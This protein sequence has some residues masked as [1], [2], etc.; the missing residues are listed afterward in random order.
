MHLVRYLVLRAAE[1][2]DA[3]AWKP[4]PEEEEED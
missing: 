1:T 3:E 2:N 4:K